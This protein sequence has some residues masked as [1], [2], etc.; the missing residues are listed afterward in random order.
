MSLRKNLN[1][2]LDSGKYSLHSPSCW[3]KWHLTVANIICMLPSGIL[4][5]TKAF[6]W[7]QYL[8]LHNIVQ[9]KMAPAGKFG[10]YCFSF[11]LLLFFFIIPQN[12]RNF[13][14][15]KNN[16]LPLWRLLNCSSLLLPFVFIFKFFHLL[17]KFF[18]FCVR[19]T[20]FS[21]SRKLLQILN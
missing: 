12:T 4:A 5:I 21:G 1:P 18:H 9:P 17:F 16:L 13:Y 2:I 19:I 8:K 10:H 7:W 14:Q 20:M 6:V 15:L 11:L 3:I